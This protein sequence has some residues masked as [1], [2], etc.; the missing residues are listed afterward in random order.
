MMLLSG[1]PLNE[2]QKQ[3]NTNSMGIQTETVKTVKSKMTRDIDV[4][5][6]EPKELVRWYNENSGSK[7]EIKKFKD[8]DTARARCSEL[9]TALMELSGGT[10]KGSKA[11]GSDKKAKSM[12]KAART[13][14]DGDKGTRGRA[15]SHAGK[16]IE[17]KVADNPRREG[18]FGFHSFNA[19]PKKGRIS[20]E[21]YIKAGGR[22]GDLRYDIE[23]EFLTIHDS[24][25]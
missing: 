20:Y 8:A 4:A 1:N 23:H 13:K 16:F 25:K 11:K 10:S 19:V 24:A 12:A 17:R 2:K 7:T 21:D 3:Q 6:A 9:K 18:S 15:S 5:K 22:S 14:I